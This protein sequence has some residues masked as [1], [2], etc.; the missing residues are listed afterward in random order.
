V[1]DPAAIPRLR[2]HVQDADDDRPVD[3]ITRGVWGAYRH[4]SSKRSSDSN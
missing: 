1:L 3:Q 2:S 4:N